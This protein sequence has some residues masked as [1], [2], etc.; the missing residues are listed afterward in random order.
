M[1]ILTDAATLDKELSFNANLLHKSCSFLYGASPVLASIPQSLDYKI[2]G[3]QARFLRALQN[4]AAALAVATDPE[5][6]RK[7]RAAA[8]GLA[9]AGSK[10]AAVSPAGPASSQL[11]G[12][13][14]K[15]VFNA[16][17]NISEMEKRKQIRDIAAAVHNQIVDGAVL[18]S[19]D[20]LEIRT[21]LEKKLR[22]WSRRA[23]CVLK[24]VRHSSRAEAHELF[25]AMDK[26]KRQYESRLETLGDSPKLM[27]LILKAHKEVVEGSADLEETLA[28]FDAFVADIAALKTAIASQ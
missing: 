19:N 27:G 23:D 16:L 12:S 22:T 14:L 25:I 10:L 9:D 2:I 26:Q 8:A 18:V 5:S 15:L 28:Q 6:I 24:R 13:V 1:V 21:A 7:L 3:Q 20:E 11:T 4:Y 17:V